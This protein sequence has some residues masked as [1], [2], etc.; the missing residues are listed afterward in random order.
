[1][2]AIIYTTPTCTWC[3]K[4]KEWL[5][6]KK[7]SYIEHDVVESD[8]AREIMIDKS[9]QMSVPVIEMGGEIIVGFDEAR[10]EEI[11]K[12]QKK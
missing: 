6:K 10:L 2:E 7:I 5:K 4:L 8:D 11:V 3:K 9:A 12:K 1:M